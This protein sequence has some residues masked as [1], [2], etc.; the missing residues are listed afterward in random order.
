MIYIKGLLFTYLL[1]LFFGAD[2]TAQ[3]CESEIQSMV[4][5]FY[6]IHPNSVGIIV[7]VESPGKNISYSYAAGYSNK[8]LK[9]VLQPQQPAL[10]ASI[11]KTYVAATILKLVEQNKITLEQPIEGLIKKKTN[12]LLVKAGYKTHEI[13]ISHI[14]SHTSGIADFADTNYHHF[15][16]KHKQYQWTRNE[17]INWALT[18]HKPLALPGDTFSYADVNYLLLSEI[19]EIQTKKPYYNAVT[20]LLE[21]EK[22]GLNST[23][24]VTLQSKPKQSDIMV[25]QYYHKYPWDSYDLNPSW[26]LYGGGGM[27]SSTKDLTT[28]FQLLF[29]GV[30]I[31]DTTL[32]SKM[33]TPVSTKTN[34]GLGIRRLVLNGHVGYYHGGWWGTDAIYF[35]ELKTAIAIFVLERSE[36]DIS[37][38]ICKQVLRI[39][40]TKIE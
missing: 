38:E 6:R 5:S 36:K 25:H 39:I 27:A 16:D 17:Q 37:S 15:V 3:T 9:A 21:F 24:F 26:D 8:E 40:N 34:Y 31:K 10:I 19:I 18:K 4:D 13:K 22:H 11:T 29:E 35:P 28:F 2:T 12:K 23:W 1:G 32:L 20:E 30:I 14:L 7:G 33:C